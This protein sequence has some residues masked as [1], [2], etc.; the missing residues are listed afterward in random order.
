MTFGERIAY[1]RKQKK[2]SQAELGKLAGINGDIIGKYERDEMRPSIETAKKISDALEVT[3]D[4][5]A[6]GSASKVLDKKTQQR[7]EDI[8]ALPDELKEKVF[9]FIDMTLRDYKAKKAYA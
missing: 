3:I 1:C 5:L 2:M 7:I 6:G 9:F 8:A 4:Y